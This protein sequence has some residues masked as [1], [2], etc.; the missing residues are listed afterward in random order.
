MSNGYPHSTLASFISNLYGREPGFP[1]PFWPHAF[2]SRAVIDFLL[3]RLKRGGHDEIRYGDF[4][5]AYGAGRA[6]AGLGQGETGKI[7][8]ASRMGYGETR[9]AFRGDVRG[10]SGVEEQDAGGAGDPRNFWHDRLGAGAGGRGR[11]SGVNR[12]GAGFAV[13]HGTERRTQVGFCAR[14]GQRSG[15]PTQ[16]RSSGPRSLPGGWLPTEADG[17]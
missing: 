7:A 1:P 14:P 10:V 5:A 6:G 11:R 13:R 17:D 3:A 8:A 2:Y 15:D 12:G 9:R 4:A 16:S